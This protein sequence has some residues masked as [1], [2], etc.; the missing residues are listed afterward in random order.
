MNQKLKKKKKFGPELKKE[1]SSE[2]Y[3]WLRN[4]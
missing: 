3:K 2:E 1:F 4:T